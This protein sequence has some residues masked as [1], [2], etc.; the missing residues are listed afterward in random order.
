MTNLATNYILVFFY[1][2]RQ[3]KFG[4]EGLTEWNYHYNTK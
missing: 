1:K 2:Y 3:L 4:F